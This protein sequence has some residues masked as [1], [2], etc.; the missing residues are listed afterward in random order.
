M[1]HDISHR[2]I[3]YLHVRYQ[4][5]GLRGP[6]TLRKVSGPELAPLILIFKY[7]GI[8]YPKPAKS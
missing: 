5:G 2:Y 7:H 6:A 3:A 1:L 4:R 8:N